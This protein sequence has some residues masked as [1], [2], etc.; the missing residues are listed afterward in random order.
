MP[1]ILQ[2]QVEDGRS[3]AVAVC[4]LVVMHT[5]GD[6]SLEDAQLDVGVQTR[7]QPARQRNDAGRIPLVVGPGR[8]HVSG[9]HRLRARRTEAAGRFSRLRGSTASS[10]QGCGASEQ[11]KRSPFQGCRCCHCDTSRVVDARTSSRLP[12]I[13]A[14]Q[15]R[16]PVSMRERSRGRPGHPA[17]CP[18]SNDDRCARIRVTRNRAINPRDNPDGLEYRVARTA[19]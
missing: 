12:C 10:N 7:D 8:R 6:R 11:Q 4:G 17:N 9:H 13:R 14:R 15:C 16:L 2:H 19:R 5:E 1:V 3:H 18:S